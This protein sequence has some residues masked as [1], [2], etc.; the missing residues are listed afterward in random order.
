MTDGKVKGEKIGKTKLIASLKE[1]EGIKV[2]AEVEVIHEDQEGNENHELQIV[3]E[4]EL[5]LTDNILTGIGFETSKESFLTKITTNGQVKFLDIN[6]NELTGELLGTG[7]K[8]IIEK[9]EQKQEYTL[10][11]YGDVTG[12]GKISPSD[13]VK[14]K[15]KILDKETM[16]EIFILASDVTKDNNISPSDYVKIKNTIL[17]KETIEQ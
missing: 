7:T 4:E 14:V 9:E 13:Y 17:G 3:F 12:D 2:E 5:K 16:D 1:Y 6:G 8:I 11:I 10:L 15:N